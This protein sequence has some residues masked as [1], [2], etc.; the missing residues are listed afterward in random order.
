MERSN[1]SKEVNFR[2]WMKSVNL[3]D[4]D[5]LHCMMEVVRY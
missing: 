5:I 3:K 1:Y 4:R 2:K